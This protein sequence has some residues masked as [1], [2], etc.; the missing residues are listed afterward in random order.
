MLSAG[1]ASSDAL[2]GMSEIEF[3][4]LGDGQVAY[5]KTMTSEEAER[6]FPQVEGLP[7]GMSLF[8]L[9]GADG[10]P[11]AL[12]DSFDAAFGHAIEDDLA[13]ASIH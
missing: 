12:T 4:A 3:A 8:A 11:I 2:K 1:K 9:H 13:V 10:S 6:L 7:A 5:I